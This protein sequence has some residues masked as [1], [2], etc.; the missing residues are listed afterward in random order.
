MLD[1]TRG[2]VRDLRQ[3]TRS[4]RLWSLYF[5]RS[6]SRPELTEDRPGQPPRAW[7]M[8]MMVTICG[9]LFTAKLAPS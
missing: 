7:V 1:R 6:N 3:E 4:A 9:A 8:F 5:R 2:T